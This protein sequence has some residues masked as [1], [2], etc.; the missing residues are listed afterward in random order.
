MKEKSLKK[1]VLCIIGA[2]GALAPLIGMCFPLLSFSAAGVVGVFATGFDMFSLKFPK[3]MRISLLAFLS[4]KFITNFEIILGILSLVALAASVTLF[5]IIIFA[6]FK[7]S[8]EK[9]IKIINLSIFI[10]CVISLANFIVSIIATVSFNGEVKDNPLFSLYKCETSSYISLILLAICIIAYIICSKLIKDK[11]SVKTKSVGEITDTTI[12][13]KS[14]EFYIVDQLH[15]EEKIVKIIREYKKLLDDDVI[16]S[17]DYI[18]IK[19]KQLSS[20]KNHNESC[21]E[22]EHLII[23]ILREYKALYTDEIITSA[24][25]IEKKGE[26]VVL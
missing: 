2:L 8:Y 5:T 18:Y 24:E 4:E 12:I 22:K 6:L 16:S 19:S 21:E 7:Y 11:S 14:K 26:L 25:F 9:S 17:S 23:Q 20:M 13:Q 10:N 3:L 1:I 15:Q